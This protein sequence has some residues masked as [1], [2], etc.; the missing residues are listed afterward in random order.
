[1]EPAA[2]ADG[3]HKWCG[4]MKMI[5][6][7]KCFHMRG[8]EHE[9]CLGWKKAGGGARR[10]SMFINTRWQ[11]MK[12]EPDSSQWYPATGQE[13]AGTNWE[14]WG[15]SRGQENT[16]FF[17]FFFLTMRVVRCQNRTYREV[18]EISL[19]CRRVFLP[20][21]QRKSIH[22]QPSV[23]TYRNRKLTSENQDGRSLSSA[24]VAAMGRGEVCRMRTP[25][26]LRDSPVTMRR[27]QARRAACLCW[28]TALGE[29][30]QRRMMAAAHSLSLNEPDLQL[31]GCRHSSQGKTSHPKVLC[32]MLPQYRPAEDLNTWA[33]ASF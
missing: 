29:V 27:D 32:W 10:L 11:G 15:S 20:I 18:L 22:C 25:Q 33:E 6:G 12:I 13:E 23:H 30:W 19:G 8:R 14:T 26:L 5:K 1:M 28:A 9:R 16:F 31:H 17:L 24:Q 3:R 4:A 21:F 2:V 7:L